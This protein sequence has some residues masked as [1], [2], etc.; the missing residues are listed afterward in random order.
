M[1]NMIPRPEHPNPQWVRENWTN[2][3]GEWQ[4]EIDHLA[5][6][7]ERGLAAA[8]SLSGK[9]NVPFCPESPLSGV[10]H[11][12]FMLGVWYK[13]TLT[14]SEEDLSGNRVILHFG[15]CDFL[16]KVWV[17]GKL[18]GTPHVGGYGSF[19]YD[20][21]RCL[22]AGDN[23]VT[24]Y[25]FDDTRS[26]RQPAGKQSL[27]HYS[28]GCRY[29]RTTGIWQTVWYEIVPESYIKYAALIPDAQNASVTVSAELCGSGDF[30]AEVFYEGKKVGEASKKN[31]SVTGML[32]VSLSETHLWDLGDGKLYDIV[33]RF[34]RDEVKS[35]FGLRHIEMKDG[36]F[37]LNGRS[38]F[39][40]LIL[41]Q[42][43]YHDGICTAPSDAALERDIRISMDAGFNGA[44][45]HERVFE[46]RFL[47]HADRL[48]Y[49][50]W[51]E[52]GNW[53]MDHSNI[54]NLANFLPDWLNTVKR[55]ISHPAVIG[56]CPFNET[57]DFGPKKKR[58]DDDLI[59]IVYEETKRL[60]PSRP[61][62]DTSGGF[63]VKT[64][65]FDLHN[66]EQNVEKYEELN[67][68]LA[69]EVSM[70]I[71]P[72]RDRETWHG[73]PVFMSEYGG[74]GIN[75]VTNADGR[76]SSWS[77]GKSAGSYEEFYARYKGLTHALL[78]NPRLMGFCYT[79]LT[80]VEQEQNGLYHY[81]DRAPKFDPA[82]LKEINQKKAAVEE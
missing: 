69:E 11:K 5:T 62:I 61:C 25:A 15:A 27:V 51:G 39:Q 80:D 43:F 29:T 76:K 34:G 56:W 50:V 26:G 40:R 54:A 82:I 22:T 19:E 67:K 75:L 44:R 20:I 31:L 64:D 49:M 41:D 10:N 66:Y 21:T 14:F 65:I 7:E 33:L 71:N 18:A 81:E 2:L 59:R 58:Q 13:R 12:E 46:P 45:L 24:V 8:P 1:A 72:R 68:K 28:V 32:E 60:D 30:S 4:F 55:D 38:V 37:Y 42:G 52:Y 78:D 63:H 77:Y 73:E 6:G 53:G 23:I 47:Y 9:I 35:Y 79:Q 16:T 70:E 48:G 3:N 17:N 36:R 74:I 57:W